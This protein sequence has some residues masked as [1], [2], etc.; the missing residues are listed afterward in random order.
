MGKIELLD[1]NMTEGLLTMTPVKYGLLLLDRPSGNLYL[2]DTTEIV[3]VFQN[4][5][6]SLVY[7]FEPHDVPSDLTVLDP[8]ESRT[9]NGNLLLINTK[10]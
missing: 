3:R 4:P 6:V 5:T 7:T 1:K 10:N 9:Q 2:L 8:K